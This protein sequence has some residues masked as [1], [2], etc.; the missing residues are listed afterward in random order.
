[1]RRRGSRIKALLQRPP[2]APGASV[3]SKTR[4]APDEGAVPVRPRLRDQQRVAVRAEG[5]ALP[6]YGRPPLRPERGS[7]GASGSRPP[8]AR[9]VRGLD[10]RRFL[11]HISRGMNEQ[12]RK[13]IELALA[14]EWDA[15]HRIVQEDDGETAAWI[16]AVCT[17]S[18]GTRTTAATGTAGR[19]SWSILAMTRA[20]NWRTSSRCNRLAAGLMNPSSGGG[21][22]VNFFDREVVQGLR[23]PGH[24]HSGRKWISPSVATARSRRNWANV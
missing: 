14:G 21:V 12:L 22:G 15:A 17:R 13:A 2:S 4:D 19:T 24:N 1:M 5:P 3:S 8:A 20:R 18:R 23:Q 7:A 11:G 16:H 9:Q 6:R 10:P